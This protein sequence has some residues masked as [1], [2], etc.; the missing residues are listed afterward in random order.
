[1]DS[2]AIHIIVGP[3]KLT[4]DKCMLLVDE[5][6]HRKSPFDT[7]VDRNGDRIKSSMLTEWTLDVR[8]LP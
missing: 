6:K 4:S 5:K 8:L 2:E 1:M 7:N 3:K